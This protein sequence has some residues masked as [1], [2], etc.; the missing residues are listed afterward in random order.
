[1][2]KHYNITNGLHVR[3]NTVETYYDHEERMKTKTSAKAN[4]SKSFN[5]INKSTQY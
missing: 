1:M 3:E 4:T 2:V 5:I